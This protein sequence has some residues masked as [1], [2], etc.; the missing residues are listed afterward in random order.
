MFYGNDLLKNSAS[1]APNA[2]V[3]WAMLSPLNLADSLELIT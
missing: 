1:H 2:G 3:D